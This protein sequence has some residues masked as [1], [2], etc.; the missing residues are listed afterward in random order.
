MKS[1][2]ILRGFK[3]LAED[4]QDEEIARPGGRDVQEPDSLAREFLG[5]P[6]LDV[7]VAR[8]REQGSRNV[9]ACGHA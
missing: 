1:C 8:P 7:C 6:S 3:S 9:Q 4:W 2:A 5:I